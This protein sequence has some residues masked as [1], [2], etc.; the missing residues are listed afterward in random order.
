MAEEYL[1][2]AA[3][4]QGSVIYTASEKD[5]DGKPTTRVHFASPP[6]VQL[7]G[8]I[9][10]SYFNDT[11]FV[12]KTSATGRY[13]GQT[14]NTIASVIPLNVGDKPNK[15]IRIKNNYNRAITINVY[16]WKGI[17]AGLSQLRELDLGIINVN[18]GQELFF[19]S[20]EYPVLTTAFPGLVIRVGMT[21]GEA[22]TGNVE[23]DI[24]AGMY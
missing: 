17:T 22:M 13:F 10:T 19:D 1:N 5:T 2:R 23:L 8:S 7:S 15:H 20:T 18:A 24:V 4:S 6:S 12:G 16:A 21:T 9:V 14:A 3:D 11:F